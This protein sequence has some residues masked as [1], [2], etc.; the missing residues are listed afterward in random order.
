MTLRRSILG[1]ARQRGVQDVAAA[2]ASGFSE[3][4]GVGLRQVGG[5]EHLYRHDQHG[6]CSAVDRGQGVAHGVSPARTN[7][8]R[9]QG[10]LIASIT[11]R[12]RLRRRLSIRCGRT[13][14]RGGQL[15]G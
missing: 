12:G 2:F 8:R 9:R 6:Q 11:F 13:A 3:I 7:L 10:C 1:S 5:R 15:L 14:K 4:D